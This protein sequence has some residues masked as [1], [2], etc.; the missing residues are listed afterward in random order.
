VTR[1]VTRCAISFAAVLSIL[2]RSRRSRSW[3]SKIRP[4]REYR[5][6]KLMTFA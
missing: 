5:G 6:E 2:W 4:A 3:L 1:L